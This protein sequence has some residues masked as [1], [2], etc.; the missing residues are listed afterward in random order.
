MT[1]YIYGLFCPLTDDLRYIGKSV[2]PDERLRRHLDAARKPKNYNQRWI[3]SLVRQGLRP[4]MS[5][6]L[7]VAQDED[8]AEVER[9]MIAEAK[10][11]GL[12]LTNTA[13]GGEGILIDDPVVE[14]RRQR[15]IRVAWENPELR[16]RQADRVKA[17]SGTAEARSIASARTRRLW[18]DPSYA[19]KVSETV[20]A[21]YSTSAAR[22]AQAE[23]SRAAHQDPE[24][25]RRRSASISAAWDRDNR[26]E[27]HAAAI[28]AAWER[29]RKAAKEK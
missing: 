14:K 9:A 15:A 27:R 28:R 21:A 8:W 6:L 12:R 29:R 18:S 26:R 16:A 5:V 4:A 10:A 13:I 2:D 22:E 24:V 19:A 17:H 20:K 11:C 3:A 7:E 23:R 25:E 1:V